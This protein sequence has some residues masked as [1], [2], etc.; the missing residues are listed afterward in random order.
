MLLEKLSNG[1]LSFEREEGV[2]EGSRKKSNNFLFTSLGSTPDL[3]A[4]GEL[5]Q[6]F[7]LFLIISASFP[8]KYSNVRDKWMSGENGFF[9]RKPTLLKKGSF[10]LESAFWEY[11]FFFK[12]VVMHKSIILSFGKRLLCKEFKQRD[13]FSKYEA[14]V[15][16]LPVQLPSMF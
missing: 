5:W 11:F 3:N 1:K 14:F 9:L 12:K 6:R 13:G 7:L 10:Q 15:D 16:F 8:R 4:K 2:R